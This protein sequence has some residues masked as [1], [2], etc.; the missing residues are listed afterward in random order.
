MT[1]ALKSSQLKQVSR[2][3]ADILAAVGSSFAVYGH[4]D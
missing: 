2:S 4:F 1:I 3:P